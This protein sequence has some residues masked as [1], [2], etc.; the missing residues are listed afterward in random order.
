MITSP[1]MRSL[2]ATMAIALSAAAGGC[3][4]AAPTEYIPETVVEAFLIVGEPIRGIRV[5]RSQSVADTF[6]Y[7]NSAVA[8][9]D[10]RLITGDRT[11]QLQYREDEHVG[12]YYLPDSTIL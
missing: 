7:A 8:D 3:E 4:D 11:F 12:E 6:R 10:V 9:A 2:M 5:T 1:L